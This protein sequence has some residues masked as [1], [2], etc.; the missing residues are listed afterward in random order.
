MIQEN[1]G[2]RLWK[3]VEDVRTAEWRFCQA[4]GSKGK[5]LGYGAD[6]IYSQIADEMYPMPS[7]AQELVR[8]WL[9]LR[10]GKG[11]QTQELWMGSLG[12]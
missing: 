12:R 7:R 6:V 3:N 1:V 9:S 10:E 2:E 4:D 11:S 8:C 5:A